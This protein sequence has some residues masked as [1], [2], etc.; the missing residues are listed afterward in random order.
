MKIVAFFDYIGYKED[1]EDIKLIIKNFEAEYP[2][3]EINLYTT[4]N[5]SDFIS[6]LS[7]NCL[8]IIDY[9]A[10][11]FIGQTGL[12]DHYDRIILNL[13]ENNSSITFC[14]KLTMGK[15]WY[16]DDLFN[17]NNVTTIDTTSDLT[18]WNKLILKYYI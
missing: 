6:H 2:D 13:I 3:K 11:N 12:K 7:S 17:Y 10:L 15:E 5:E 18:K 1:I 16:K 4:D 9:G 8:A 14:F